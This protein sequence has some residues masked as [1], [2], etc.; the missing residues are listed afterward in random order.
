LS[1]SSLDRQISGHGLVSP[2]PKSYLLIN[3]IYFFYLTTGQF[4]V[5]VP[6]T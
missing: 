1:S 2:Y 4:G 3:E 5:K 6:L